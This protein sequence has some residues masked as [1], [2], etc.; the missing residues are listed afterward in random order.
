MARRAT[1]MIRYLSLLAVLALVAVLLMFSIY[2]RARDDAISQLLT[3]E[4]ILSEETTTGIGDYFRY[5]DVT[6][7]FIV[8]DPGV[9]KADGRG[10]SLLRQF[11]E[12]QSDYFTGLTRVDEVGI[13]KYSVPDNTVAGRD[14]SSQAHVARIISSHKAS[15]S[16][17]FRAVQ[18]YDAVAVHYPVFD[19][20]RYA[21][22][23]ALLI[24]FATIS[25]RYLEN[26]RV[27]A[28]GSALLLDQDC[29]EIYGPDFSHL[30]VSLY[31]TG[32]SHPSVPAMADAIRAAGPA[33]TGAV[34]FSFP[35]SGMDGGPG[36]A[37][38]AW[39]RSIPVADGWWTVVVAAPESEALASIVGFR[40]R[41]ILLIAVVMSMFGLWAFLFA[42][43]ILADRR[44]AAQLEAERERGRI[45]AILDAAIHQ[46]PAAILVAD[47]ADGELIAANPAA[48]RVCGLEGMKTDS[49]DSAHGTGL[50][51]DKV[52]LPPGACPD[53]VQLVEGAIRGESATGRPVRLDSPEGEHWLMANSAPVRESG[54]AIIAGIVVL[55]DITE[56]K[57]SESDIRGFNAILERTVADRTAELAQANA[58]LGSANAALQGTLGEL[59]SAQSQLV[60]SEKLAVLGQLSASIAHQVN[61][62]LGAIN[63]ASENIF[64]ILEDSFASVFRRYSALGPEMRGIY[65]VLLEETVLRK[66]GDSLESSPNRDERRRVARR[67]AAMAGIAE[68]DEAADDLWDMGLLGRVDLAA[69]LMAAAGPVILGDLFR[70]ASM[71]ISARI[72]SE[73]A[74][75]ASS[76]IKA[77]G[78]YL[79]EGSLEEAH[80]LD[81]SEELDLILALYEERFRRGVRLEK[82][83]SVGV[84]ACVKAK[85]LSQVWSNLILNA[86]QAMDYDGLLELETRIEG[87]DAV[88]EVIDSG[89]GI[90]RE[91][92]QR[93]FEPFFTTKAAGE[94]SGLGLAV[95]RRIVLAEGGSI[96]FESVPG[97]TRFTVRLP[98]W[99]GSA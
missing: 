88:I 1:R 99:P 81:L 35:K 17:V 16:S 98:A 41:G 53:L 83:L 50:S 89:R 97:R 70:L 59:R 82:R 28:T 9:V 11:Y 77:L 13:I 6:A 37:R 85:G 90:P 56:L 87:S 51:M 38:R 18:G 60:L 48:L 54:G 63:S 3:Q 44:A 34:S 14:I 58:S 67:L 61:T 30:G 79:S 24:P 8:N 45:L 73:A 71:A 29:V 62:P 32:K 10:L 52:S 76:V 20:D 49:T 21:G 66:L 47:S 84:R 36:I 95:A 19:G 43:T 68:A 42:R 57:H 72:I 4:R 40:D 93:I 2:N 46:S 65:D 27:A 22:S 33:G 55:N 7:R 15:L 96:N 78:L 91:L 92:A 12:A 31:Q 86:L 94:G 23:L 80:P 75:K 74:G 26:V 39:F 5:L 64:S 25:R 69:E